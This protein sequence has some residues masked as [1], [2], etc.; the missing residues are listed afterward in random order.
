M[1]TIKGMIGIRGI[2]IYFFS[3]WNGSGYILQELGLSLE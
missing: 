1:Q 2:F 3:F